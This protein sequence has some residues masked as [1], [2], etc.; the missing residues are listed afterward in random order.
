MQIAKYGGE[1]VK[2]GKLFTTSSPCELCS[3]KA[4]QIGIKAIYYIDPYP[5]IA[6]EQILESGGMDYRPAL[7]LFDG[8]IGRAYHQLYEPIMAYKDELDALLD[9][10]YVK[11]EE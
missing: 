10:K 1:G 7:V 6:G 3:K 11:A 9:I 8:A 4:Y 2:G 5:R